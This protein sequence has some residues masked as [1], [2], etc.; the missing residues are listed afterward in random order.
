MRDLGIATRV[1]TPTLVDL[2][3]AA[4]KVRRLLQILRPFSQALE[5]ATVTLG[6]TSITG[7]SAALT[8]RP[9][10]R[11]LG[12]LG[13]D[14]TEPANNLR[15][16]LNDLDNRKRSVEPD[17]NAATQTGNPADKI[18]YTGLE[19]P[20]QYIFDQ[21]QAINIFDQRGYSL[22]INVNPDTCSDYTTGDQA[23]ADMARYRKCNQNLGPNQPGITTP[24]PSPP[25]S[26]SATASSASTAKSAS[27]RSA[28]ARR[29]AAS[30]KPAAT[31]TP[32]GKAGATPTPGS[33]KPNVALPPVQ[34]LIDK[35]PQLI[36]QPAG[37]RKHR[38]HRRPGRRPTAP[39][40]VPTVTAPG[41]P[42]TQS[43]QD[44]L[45]FLFSP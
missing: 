15:I 17:P 5:P 20:L 7:R 2:R 25:L 16:I 33:S 32:S 43:A 26:R 23:K 36:H 35:L 14:I 22:K 30:G 24:D 13:N 31:S 41:A 42:S 29:G 28:H 10:V 40:A 38:H 12:G 21:S 45:D 6:K 27:S 18:G 9:L 3:A 44:L 1:N 34:Q 8:A 11:Q 4:P 19:A 39:V 37:K